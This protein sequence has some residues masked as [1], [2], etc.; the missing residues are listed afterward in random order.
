[1]LHV[2]SLQSGFIPGDSIVNPLV[3]LCHIFTEAVDVG[4][5]VS[6]VFCDNSKAL[7]C[8]LHEGLIDKLKAAGVS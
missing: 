3:Y 6:V 2:S 7:D 8:V 1:M 5:E 4:K